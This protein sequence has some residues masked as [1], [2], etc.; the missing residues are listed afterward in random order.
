MMLKDQKLENY[1]FGPEILKMSKAERARTKTLVK[2]EMQEI[3][4]CRNIFDRE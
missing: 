3:F 2:K 4:E 1:L